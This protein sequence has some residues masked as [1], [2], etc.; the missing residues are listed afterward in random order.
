MIDGGNRSSRC[1]QL[2]SKLPCCGPR[3]MKLGEAQS[4]KVNP[5]RPLE[6][7]NWPSIFARLETIG[8]R[9]EISRLASSPTQIAW[10]ALNRRA[11]CGFCGAILYPAGP[12]RKFRDLPD[13]N[14]KAVLLRSPQSAPSSWRA[15]R[16]RQLL[17]DGIAEFDSLGSARIGSANV[18]TRSVRHH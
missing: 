1:A 7:F 2:R 4:S 9:L 8:E 3:Q 17:G 11:V 6:A 10:P 13:P 15:F 18:E 12:R 14:Q 16:G 5:V